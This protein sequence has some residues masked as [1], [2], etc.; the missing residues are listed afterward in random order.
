MG[1]KHIM[2]HFFQFFIFSLSDIFAQYLFSVLVFKPGIFV[3][4][5]S[6][7]AARCARAPQLAQSWTGEIFFDFTECLVLAHFDYFEGVC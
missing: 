2:F 1:P 3:P 7:S 6:R 4:L 5:D